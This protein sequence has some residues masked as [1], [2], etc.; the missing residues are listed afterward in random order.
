MYTSEV[1]KLIP[2]CLIVE[3]ILRNSVSFFL[4]SSYHFM[5]DSYQDSVYCCAALTASCA[6]SSHLQKWD[7]LVSINGISLVSDCHQAA[8]ESGGEEFFTVIKQRLQKNAKVPRKVRF[9]RI[10]RP[11]I[12]SVPSETPTSPSFDISLN[13][14]DVSVLFDINQETQIPMFTIGEFPIGKS[15]DPTSTSLF[16]ITF[17]SSLGIRIWP[18]LLIY[19]DTEKLSISSEYDSNRSETIQGNPNGLLQKLKEPDVYC[20][21]AEALSDNGSISSKS[22]RS[23]SM[24]SKVK[25]SFNDFLCRI[26]SEQGFST[27]KSLNDESVR[28]RTS[29]LS[30]TTEDSFNQNKRFSVSSMEQKLAPGLSPISPLVS[31]PQFGDDSAKSSI[32]S[33]FGQFTQE[34]RPF[35][36]S[37]PP[38]TKS[39]DGN[40]NREPV[41]NGDHVPH[42]EIFENESKF[43]QFK[44]ENQPFPLS[45]PPVAKS[46]DNNIDHEFLDDSDIGV[47]CMQP[48]NASKFGQF[49]LENCQFPF[50][51]PPITEKKIGTLGDR[52][53]DDNFDQEPVSH[54]HI[55]IGDRVSLVKKS[56]DDS[57]FGQFTQKNQPFPFSP[58][59]CATNLDVDISRDRVDHSDIIVEVPMSPEEP[60][61]NESKFGQF[62]LENPPAKNLF[63]RHSD[64]L[65]LSILKDSEVSINRLE[66]GLKSGLELELTQIL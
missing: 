62:T 19:P 53:L 14:F 48:I 12:S 28:P 41:D 7:I 11:S 39:L 50:S 5:S 57:K 3:K 61:Q 43:D 56:G 46:L 63:K 15:F 66:L 59:P 24:K 65:S 37:P 32:L 42:A 8:L 33:K 44:I 1:E 9:L 55:A 25:E 54:S 6:I 64:T 17:P 58:P 23:E 4:N 27:V 16:E 21:Q 47:D 29:I 30:C 52:S 51:P 45:P 20:D 60:F 40:I 31:S 38:V 36:F 22:I 35:P 34:N 18:H 2:A 13:S 26:A 10:K 49:T